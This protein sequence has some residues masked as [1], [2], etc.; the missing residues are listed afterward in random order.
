MAVPF[1]LPNSSHEVV[2]N[3]PLPPSANRLWGQGGGVGKHRV[4]RTPE[5]KAWTRHADKIALTQKRELIPQWFTVEILL[6]HSGRMA[7][8]SDSDNRIKAVLD[9][10]QRIHIIENDKYCIGGSW[11]WAPLTEAP[12]GCKVIVR[13][14]HG[15]HP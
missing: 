6:H 4:F 15:D 2:L 12:E 8:S 14:W 3:L 5:Y 11:R 1:A 13:T 10:L 7:R 9:Y